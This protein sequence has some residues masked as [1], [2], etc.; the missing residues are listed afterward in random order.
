MKRKGK[1]KRREKERSSP[2]GDVWRLCTARSRDDDRRKK[3][4]KEREK[5]KK[6]RIWIVKKVLGNGWGF[7]DGLCIAFNWRMPKPSRGVWQI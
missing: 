5:G 4:L 6:M 7:E 3:K 1:K 2:G